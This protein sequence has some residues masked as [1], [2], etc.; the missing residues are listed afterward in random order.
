MRAADDFPCQVGP[1]Y[2]IQDITLGLQELRRTPQLYL[3]ICVAASALEL[4]FGLGGLGVIAEIVIGVFAAY[5]LI[6]IATHHCSG[7]VESAR[8]DW[9]LKG[10]QLGTVL[11]SG[12]MI[13]GLGFLL[14]IPVSLLALFLVGVPEA[15]PPE[16][17]E[18]EM[19]TLFQQYVG[20]LLS[21]PLALMVIFCGTVLAL[22]YASSRFVLL[23]II[24]VAWQKPL[25]EAR[26][27]QAA[28]FLPLRRR[29]FGVFA[30]A[31]GLNIALGTT[32]AFAL[33]DPLGIVV[34]VFIGWLV[35]MALPLVAAVNLLY[36]ASGGG[37]SVAAADQGGGTT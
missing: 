34:G 32:L 18:A 29:A 7:I 22:A 25:A 5:Y 33:P 1:L 16:A 14:M 23:P 17:S 35:G 30:L 3:M 28:Q 19:T 11:Y 10:D 4:I 8:I 24:S 27:M 31:N 37:R 13:I 12:A 15:P 20:R 36:R 9:R 26:A 6:V 21:S 2:L